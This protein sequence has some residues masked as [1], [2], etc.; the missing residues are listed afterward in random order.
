MSEFTA[1]FYGAHPLK[2]SV[3]GNPRFE[4]NTSQGFYRTEVD[5]QIGYSVQNYTNTRI[6]ESLV[7]KLVVFTTNGK[8]NVIAMRAAE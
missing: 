1:T 8:N 7:E 3:N 4:L 5:G 2:Y 6:S